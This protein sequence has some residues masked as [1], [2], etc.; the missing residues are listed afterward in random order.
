M[1]FGAS[2]ILSFVISCL[3]LWWVPDAPTFHYTL[4]CATKSQKY[5]VFGGG[6]L[7][8]SSIYISATYMHTEWT[9]SHI[10]IVGV[11]LF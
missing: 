5:R 9:T 4:V 6:E 11:I 3:T 7:V 10:S 2:T 8:Q 1:I